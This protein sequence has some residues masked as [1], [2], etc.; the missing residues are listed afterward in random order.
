MRLLIVE[1][2]FFLGEALKRGLELGGY[3]VHW[4]LRGDDLLA[5]T[6][7]ETYEVILLDLELPHLSGLDA[8]RAL[9]GRRDLTP[10]VIITAQDRSEQKIAGL[11]AGADDYL[12]KPIDLDEVMARIR[13]QIRRRDQ[14]SD[15]ELIVG[16]I[17]LDLAGRT[18]AQGGRMVLLTSKEYR[19]LAMLMRR[20]RR[21]VSKTEIESEIYDD[22]AEI[23][24]NTVEV[25][26]SALR[27]KL[28]REAI[29]TARGLGY[30]IAS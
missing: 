29:I 7:A 23:E 18:V 24:S 2:D 12:V 10:V 19:I 8:L 16:D 1:D 15:N 17:R 28:G 13:A 25:T 22:T 9:R 20:V 5:A 3:D 14:R 27:R 4:I 21:F 6:T 11:D 30:M 26:I